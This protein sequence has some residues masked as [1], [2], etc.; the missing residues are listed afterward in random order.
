MENINRKPFDVDIYFGFCS[1]GDQYNRI[2]KIKIGQTTQSIKS[3][4]KGYQRAFIDPIP[5]ISL[6]DIEEY[7]KVYQRRYKD[8]LE[9]KDNSYAQGRLGKQVEKFVKFLCQKRGFSYIKNT[10]GEWYE[11]GSDFAKAKANTQ[12]IYED[13]KKALPSVFDFLLDDKELSEENMKL[14]YADIRDNQEVN[15]SGADYVVKATPALDLF[16]LK[17]AY[18]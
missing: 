8:Y 17:I 15:R 14:I 1:V 6:A 13:L 5:T 11:L 16:L 7:R 4:F 10:S 12:G 3:R 2:H 9:E 18:N